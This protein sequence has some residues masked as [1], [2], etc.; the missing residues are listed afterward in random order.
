MYNLKF[1]EV[2][3]MINFTAAMKNKLEE[4]QIKI[5]DRKFKCYLANANSEQT[6]DRKFKRFLANANSEQTIIPF[7][8]GL[9]I[10]YIKM[11]SYIFMTHK[12]A[13]RSELASRG[14]KPLVTEFTDAIMKL[15]DVAW[16]NTELNVIIIL[17][18]EMRWDLL[19]FCKDL[20]DDINTN[21]LTKYQILVKLFLST[22]KKGL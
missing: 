13:T 20:T 8:H 7:L 14:F 4:L 11:D 18:P 15:G 5:A 22:I 9:N 16:H 12:N 21:D 2:L 1:Y 19:K 6:F 3:P 17:I 10:E